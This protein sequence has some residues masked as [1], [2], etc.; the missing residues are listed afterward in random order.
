MTIPFNYIETTLILLH[1]IKKACVHA[2]F[3][4]S[5][6]ELVTINYWSTNK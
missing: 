4:G 1:D 2:Q 6:D 3:Y 5:S